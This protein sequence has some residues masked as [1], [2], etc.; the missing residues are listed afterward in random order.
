[1]KCHNVGYSLPPERSPSTHTLYCKPGRPRWPGDT[2]KVFG[3]EH[4]P[5]PSSASFGTLLDE[6]VRRA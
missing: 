5:R 1:V 3:V 2:V 6:I 4:R